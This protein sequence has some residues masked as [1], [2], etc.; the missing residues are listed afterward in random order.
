MWIRSEDRAEL[1]GQGVRLRRELAPGDA[2][3][4]VARESQ[5]A[6]SRAVALEGLSRRVDGVAVRSTTTRWSGQTASGSYG[7][8]GSFIVGCGSPYLSPESRKAVSKSL[9]MT[10]SP[11][12]RWISRA[13]LRA[14]VPLRRGCRAIRAARETGLA[15]RR[16]SAW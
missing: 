12:W 11:C 15:S 1:V 13:R 14:C 9:R 16:I 2:H 6:I 4:P 8:S 5:L 7:P 3:D 10:V